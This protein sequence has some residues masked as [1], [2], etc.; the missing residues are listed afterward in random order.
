MRTLIFILVFIFLYYFI[1]KY[2][3]PYLIQRFIRK[4][5]EKFGQY[6][7]SQNRQEVKKEGEVTIKYVPPDAKE[8]KFNPETTE[9]VDFE[10]IN[11]K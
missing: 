11:N 3:F 10:E 8:S 4:A 5:G 7:Q 1:S 9:D 6:Q 2:L